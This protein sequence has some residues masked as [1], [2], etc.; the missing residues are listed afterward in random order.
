MFSNFI[1]N[2]NWSVLT[3]AVLFAIP[4]LICITFHELAHGFTAYRLGDTTA[5]DMGRLTFNPL[6][7]LDI[8]GFIML[9]VVH[10]GWAKPV[11][12]N[13]YRFKR[14]KWYMA[15]TAIAGPL[16]NIILAVIVFF[17]Y[18]LVLTPLRGNAAN[19]SGVGEFILAIVERTAYLNISLAVFNVIPIPPLDGSKV[20]FSFF[21]EATYYKLMRYERYGII[22]LILVVT[23]SVFNNTIGQWTATLVSK[24]TAVAQFAYNLVN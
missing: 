4:A 24:F 15:V 7:H 2:L 23:T 11:P 5:K 1:N 3:N 16:S 19:P 10:F 13:M 18:G 21:P 12:V 14:P 22:L 9:M 17:I 8:F 20:L 6:K